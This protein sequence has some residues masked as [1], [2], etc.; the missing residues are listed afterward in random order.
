M[1]VCI[2]DWVGEGIPCFTF[3][4]CYILR[5]RRGNLCDC[6][7]YVKVVAYIIYCIYLFGSVD[8]IILVMYT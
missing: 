5:D 6:A 2:W 8:I 7:G 4:D 3:V 1:G